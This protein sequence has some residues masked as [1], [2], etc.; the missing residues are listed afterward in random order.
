M[1]FLI[2]TLHLSFGL[3]N[4][5]CPPTSIFH[6]LITTYSTHVLTISVSLLL[7]PHLCLPHLPLLLILLSWSSQSSLF[8]SFI[9]TYSSLLF[10]ANFSQPF[11]VVRSRVHTLEQVCSSSLAEYRIQLGESTFESS[12]PF[13]RLGNCVLSKLSLC[14]KCSMVELFP[15]MWSW[16]QNEQVCQ[17]LK[18]KGLWA[19][20]LSCHFCKLISRTANWLPWLS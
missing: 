19:W 5:Q 15:D 12:F 7:F 18:D 13:R 17:E 16:H 4:C 11:T 3:S 14:S 20:P 1:S 9:A 10:L 2:T 8:P 6:V